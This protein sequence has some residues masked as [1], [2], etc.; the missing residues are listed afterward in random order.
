MVKLRILNLALGAG[1]RGFTL[2]RC[3]C[4]IRLFRVWRVF[5]A[6]FEMGYFGFRTGGLR[7]SFFFVL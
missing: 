5:K 3:Q 4:S 7:L 1:C 2:L 6:L